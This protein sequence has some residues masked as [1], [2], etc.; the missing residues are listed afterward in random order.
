KLF[1]VKLAP[2]AEAVS[3]Y[4]A[5]QIPLATVVCI[6]IAVGQFLKFKKTDMASFYKK[7]TLSVA[8]SV[9]A[10]AL[11]TLFLREIK[12]PYI[13]MLFATAFAI[14]ANADYLFLVLKGNVQKAGASTAHIGFGLILLGALISNSQKHIISQNVKGVNLGKDF[15]NRENIMMELRSDTL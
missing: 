8:I 13:I 10:T 5:W 1:S 6:L 3:H 4:N 14:A 7:M 2:P 12:V 15:P 11:G 9:V